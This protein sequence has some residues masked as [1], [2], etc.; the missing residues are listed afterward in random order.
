M[1]KILSFIF[2]FGTSLSVFANITMP[3]I[4][5]DNMV[6]QRNKLIHVWGWASSNEKVNVQFNKQ[7]K[8]T[9]TDKA[10]KWN[11]T[12]DAEEAGGPYQLIIKGKNQVLFNNILVGEVW[13]CSGQSNMEMPIAGWGKINNYIQEIKDANYP[14]IR[15][16][17]IPNTTSAVPKEDIAGG[18]WKVCNSEN[19]G[20]FSATAYFFARELYNKLKVPVGIINST[21]GGTQI[22]SWISLQAFDQS[23]EFKNIT[24][25]M[26]S[27]DMPAIIQKR[28]EARL[29]N[30]EKIVGTANNSS[31]IAEWRNENFDDSKWALMK[32][33]GVWES[34]GMADLDGVVWFRKTVEIKNEDAGKT[35]LIELS[36]IDDMDETYINGVKIGAMNNWDDE[37]RY[38]IPS[39]ILKAGKNTIV[40]KITDN[41]GGGGFYGNPADIK[42]S[43]D[44]HTI[45]L[46]GEWKYKVES[47]LKPS[48]TIGPNDYPCIL[49]NA[50]IHPITSY[51]IKGF[52]WYQGESN[53]ERAYQY[54]K[55]FP[56][57][58]TDWRKQW[59]EPALPFYFV[60]LSTFGSANAN[61]NNGSKWGELRESQT[62]TLSLPNTAMAVTT[63]IGNP[64]DIHPKN[65]QD[66]GKR[67]AAIALHNLYAQQGVYTGPAYQS[68]KIQGDKI[69]ISFSNTDSGW[70]VKD[71]YGYIKGFEIAGEDKKF[72]FAKALV[73]GNNI[74]V[75][76]ESI[77][78]PVAVRY[79]WADDASEGNLFNSNYFPAAPFRTDN[80]KLITADNKFVIM[81]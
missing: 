62:A 35:A 70:F 7:I 33:P 27:G 14:A 8:N 4:F 64:S 76:Q 16:F 9:K 47:V 58:I 51:T 61:S 72:Q 28:N 19:A 74:I 31:N 3:K 73:D 52:L 55:A 26:K 23:D 53:E 38:T 24:E 21:W 56:L 25:V 32:V 77:Q 17:D 20:E 68:M 41:G 39:G 15:Q 43:I 13:V 5:G 79:N 12:L 11:I 75:F 10:G 81:P 63:D 50:M 59:N 78:H 6:L 66:V 65:K 2:C 54:R 42:L 40:V 80:W 69:S 18:E 36:K 71:K 37:R 44:N 57:M 30:I 29:K 48:S 1:K 22:E 45:A 67:L 46:T 49:F 34:Q 60:Q